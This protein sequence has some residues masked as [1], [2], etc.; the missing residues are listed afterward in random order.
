MNENGREEKILSLLDNIPEEIRMVHILPH[1]HPETLV[2][3]D[4]ANYIKY[5]SKIRPY[6][7][8]QPSTRFPLGRQETY[9]RNMVRNDASFVF[10]Q[11]LNERVKHWLRKCNYYY[12]GKRF[13]T[14]LHFLSQYCIDLNAARCR[15]LV[16]N[17]GLNA[18][19]KK[20]YKKSKI[21]SIRWIH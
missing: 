13:E 8:L 21:T 10:S 2:W 4:K 11:L 20:W 6:I 17:A 18:M 14:Y 12:S 9:I 15:Q 1:L 7:S 19:G 5:H 16:H 3:L